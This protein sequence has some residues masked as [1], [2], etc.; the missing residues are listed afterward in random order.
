[1]HVDGLVDAYDAMCREFKVVIDGRIADCAE[2][3]EMLERAGAVVSC[4][5]GDEGLG[6]GE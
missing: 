3:E 1:M 4:D 6:D 2:A 5:T